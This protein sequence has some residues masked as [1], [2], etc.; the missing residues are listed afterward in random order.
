MNEEPYDIGDQHITMMHHKKAPEW[1]VPIT[2]AVMIDLSLTRTD[3]LIYSALYLL[4][5]GD[6]GWW[7]GEQEDIIP[8]YYERL[9]T[10]GLKPTKLPGKSTVS[11]AIHRLR[12]KNL[13][14]TENMGMGMN[15]ILKYYVLARKPD[16]PLRHKRS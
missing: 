6:N 7:Y 14:V 1:W 12:K 8:K 10:Y 4:A 15:G 2:H 16:L 13:L 3:L 5:G 9:T 11:V